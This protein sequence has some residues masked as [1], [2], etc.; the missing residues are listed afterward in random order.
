MAQLNGL[1]QVTAV[2]SLFKFFGE[3]LVTS[4]S[5]IALVT[6][7]SSGIGEA[8][9]RLLVAHQYRVIGAARN[10]SKLKALADELG[11]SFHPLDLDVIDADSVSSLIDRLPFELQAIDV[12]INNAGHDIGGRRS[13][14]LGTAA[15]WSHTIET[16]VQGLM[17]VTHAVIHGMLNRGR[18]HILN[19]GSIAGIKPF[20]TVAAYVASKYAVHGFSESLRLDYA[21]K[22]IRVSEIMPGMVRTG[23]A[24]ERLGDAN[25]ADAFYDSFD[26]LLTPEDIAE[27]VLFALQ[28]P[29]HVEI[30]EL[31]VMPVS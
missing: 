24:S 1:K 13:F 12:L 5:T 15:Q 3:K 28:Q 10:M 30:S 14:E 18:G 7:A 23:F 19:M 2:T 22:G 26:Q 4:T 25:A 16:N 29:K 17:R 11:E 6:G 31:V 9:S 8:I 20:A 27:T 21:G